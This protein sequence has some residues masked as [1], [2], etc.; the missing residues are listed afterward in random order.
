MRKVRIS[1]KN[2]FHHVMNKGIKSETVFRDS[3]LKDYFLV[4]LR[5]LSRKYGVEVFAYVIMNNHYHILLRNTNNNL[6]KFMM[7]LNGSFGLFYRANYGGKGYVFQGR[8]KSTIIENE[9]YLIDCLIYL[10]MNP[11]RAGYCINPFDYPYS[12]LPELLLS[13]IK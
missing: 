7:E 6:S 11:V 8:F 12:S 9:E 1:Y 10:Y 2:A 5:K 13:N 4:Q 3:A